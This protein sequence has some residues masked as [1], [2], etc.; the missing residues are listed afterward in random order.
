MPRYKYSIVRFVPSPTRGE[1]VNLGVIVGCDA[2]SEWT[3]EIVSKK[4]RA[5]KLD[6]ARVLPMVSAE[7][8]RLQLRFPSDDDDDD[9][10]AVRQE[11]T[12]NEGWLSM[13]AA[14][15]QNVIQYSAP[16]VMLAED[17]NAAKEK[18]WDIFIVESVRQK[19][20]SLSKRQV[21]SQ[22]LKALQ[23]HHL[24]TDHLKHHTRL[25]T[26]HNSASIDVAVH[27]GVAK[28]LTQCWSLQ[29]KDTESVLN[30][31]KAWGWTMKVLR[32][33]GGVI[34]TA[35]VPIEVPRDVELSVILA[36]ATDNRANEFTEEATE[37]LSDVEVSAQR[38][39]VEQ[40]VQHAAEVASLLKIQIR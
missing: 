6:D 30:E 31:V 17:V 23:A 2:T 40:M 20:D 34:T 26:S 13:I 10:D 29:V 35:S 25:K 21:L 16:Q 24:G 37:V 5:A 7:L 36:T 27:N 38:I 32:H 12:I 28:R 39:S 3:M 8:E 18:L 14:Q 9:D 22:Y 4:S 11:S 33:S 1:Q 19:R 15:S